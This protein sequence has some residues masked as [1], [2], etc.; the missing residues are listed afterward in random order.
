VAGLLEALV[1]GFRR[2]EGPAVEPSPEWSDAARAVLKNLRWLT[3]EG[4]VLE[5]PNT[6]LALGRQNRPAAQDAAASAAKE[7][8][9]AQSKAKSETKRE[10]KPRRDSSDTTTPAPAVAPPPAARGDLDE[11]DF[12]LPAYP[13]ED[14]GEGDPDDPHEL[15]DSVNPVVTF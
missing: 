7:P 5:F 4:Y 6:G 11:E 9:Q 8:K 1:P 12:V 13:P 15:P 2:S 14:V 3:A 10:R